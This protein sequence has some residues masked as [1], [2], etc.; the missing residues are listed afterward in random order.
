[1]PKRPFARLRWITCRDLP[2]QVAVL[3][4]SDVRRE[5]R[6]FVADAP[7]PYDLVWS[8]GPA[9][10]YTLGR[11]LRVV[12]LVIDLADVQWALIDQ[13]LRA[14]RADGPPRSLAE[15]RRRVRLRVDR[16]RWQRFE[17]F[18]SGRANFVTVCS[19]EDRELHGI[20][21]A[22][23]VPNGYQQPALRCGRDTVG[24]PPVIVFPGQMTY[25][26]NFDGATWLVDDVLPRLRARIPDVSVRIVGR[27]GA[28]LDPLRGREGVEVVGYVDRI[29]D[30]LARA[31][32]IAV[33]L[34]QGSGT[35]IKIIEAWAHRIPVVS[36]TIGAEGLGATDGV[37]LLL[38][39]DASLFAAALERALTDRSRRASMV[40]AGEAR[41]AAEYDWDVIGVPFA[42]RVAETVEESHRFDGVARRRSRDDGVTA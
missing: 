2:L 41:F 4:P 39:D 22:V 20:P 3:D 24:A 26:P 15:L 40:A 5:L 13:S 31:D 42:R 16:D 30:E 12:P 32:V 18:E 11:A 33:P 36:T 21:G 1:V 28:E 19:D 17:R 6:R 9:P 29:E 34:R 37:E 14:R 8:F 10:S 23:V 27:S 35:R 7:E 25:R 38:A